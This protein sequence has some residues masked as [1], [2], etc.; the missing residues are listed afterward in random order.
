MEKTFE[1][2]SYQSSKLVT[3]KYSTSCSLGVAFLHR[4]IRDDIHSIYSFV[5]FA[6]EIVDT[7]HNYDKKS[8][9]NK[10]EQDYY[11]AYNDGIS[12]N[13]ILI[14]FQLTVKKYNINDELVQA[15]LKSM[16]NDLHVTAY[17]ENSYKEYIYGSADVVGLMCLKVFVNGDEQLYN[18]LRPAALRLGSAF[19]KT[20]FLRDLG[21]DVNELQRRYFP[22]L[23]N[24][25][26]TDETKK[27]IVDDIMRDYDAAL[28]G[29]IRLPNTA[30]VGVYSAYAYYRQ[31]TKKLARI[32]V[33]K[34]MTK[35][36]RISNFRKAWLLARTYV[37]VRLGIL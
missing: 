26:L 11:Q 34:V 15:F 30:K 17:D 33:N 13:P 18:E 37:I 4:S 21:N 14:S 25:E 9:L 10:F 7:F 2:L 5:R 22:E 20:N 16:K 1:K 32:N 35:R 27:Q 6:D 24:R 29:I 28:Q 12:L 8:L 23:Q 31:L 3:R 36:I 19:P